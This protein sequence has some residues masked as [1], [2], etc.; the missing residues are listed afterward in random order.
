MGSAVWQNMST[1]MG[2]TDKTSIAVETGSGIKYLD[3]TVE[4]NKVTM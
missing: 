1:I 4:N 3:L 2:L